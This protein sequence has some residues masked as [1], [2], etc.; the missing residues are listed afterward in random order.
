[1]GVDP[2]I[3]TALEAAVTADPENAALRTHLAG[4]LV[5]A[6]LPSRALEHATVVL[7]NFP[8]DGGA[9]KVAHLAAEA[10]GN[11]DLAA[12]YEQIMRALNGKGPAPQHAIVTPELAESSAL[13]AE[14]MALL[15]N[16]S[17]DGLSLSTGDVKLADVAG[18]DDIKAEVERKFLAPMRN[19]ELRAMYRKSLRGGLL[20]YGPPGCGKTFLARAIAG[21]LGASFLSVGLHEVLGMWLGSSERNIHELFER[22]RRL[23]PC[24]V[25]IDE[26]D[27][28]GQKRTNLSQSALRGSVVQL[29]SEL[30]G[31][32]A[33][34]NDGVFVLG[35]TNQP[36]DIDP[37]L[38]RPGRFDRTVLV[39]PPDA[40]ARARILAQHLRDR[41][42]ADLDL[43][44]LAKITA[45]FSG[46][47]LRLVCETAAELAI[48]DSLRDGHAR[49]IS[50]DHLE[51]AVEM[52][53]PST[54]SWFELARN[55]VTFA[56]SGGEYDRLLEYMR[57]QRL[58]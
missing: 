2:S 46:A 32:D 25:F 27:A 14:L 13:D 51:R 28:L 33:D 36:W 38:R 21:E 31:V 29:L 44:R 18:L 22:A 19:P 55:F 58:L 35:A 3:V 10:L 4:V 37:A 48:D 41:P 56:N 54:L 49:P 23:A 53:A 42:V 43:E 8:A 12:G 52:T 30:D 7:G 40:E 57:A 47:D 45:R 24:V 39:V 34:Q 6:D 15:H 5:D 17:G 11:A 9:L 50:G 20:L 16:E 26:V 1:M